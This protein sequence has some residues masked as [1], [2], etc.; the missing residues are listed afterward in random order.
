MAE[1]SCL[2]Y[3]TTDHAASA[4]TA[5]HV[6]SLLANP[7]DKTAD[8]AGSANVSARENAF[9]GQGSFSFAQLENKVQ[10]TFDQVKNAGELLHLGHTSNL[11]NSG[12]KPETDDRTGCG[13]TAVEL[14]P[15]MPSGELQVKL[16]RQIQDGEHVAISQPI[17]YQF[18]PITPEQRQWKQDHPNG[19]EL[20]HIVH[21]QFRAK[22]DEVKDHKMTVQLMDSKP[23]YDQSMSERVDLGK[24][25]ADPDGY[26]TYD[27]Y[28]VV[29][30]SKAG[31]KLNLKFNF[32]SEQP[33]GKID[34]KDLSLQ[35]VTSAPGLNPADVAQAAS[36]G[37]GSVR[38]QNNVPFVFAA[39]GNQ[40]TVQ[41]VFLPDEIREK[42]QKAYPGQPDKQ[43]KMFEQ[44]QQEHALTPEQQKTYLQKMK[45]M[46]I[47]CIHIPIYWNQT[48]TQ[49]GKTDYAAVDHMIDLAKSYGMKVELDP[50][51][52]SYCYPGWADKGGQTPQGSGGAAA[53][54]NE[55]NEQQ[56]KSVTRQHI[57]DIIQHFG[58]RADFIVVNEMN[59]TDLATRKK[60]DANGHAQLEQ[61]HNGLTDWV[62]KEGPAAVIN[63]VDRWAREDLK[64]YGST[65]K[66]LENEYDVDQQTL[67]S[68]AV[69]SQD[70]NRPDALGIQMH[71]FNGNYPV[72]R[73]AKE[74][75]DRAQT[76]IPDYISEI[77][78]DTNPAGRIDQS[79][80]PPEV[81]LAVAKEDYYRK[82]HNLSPLTDA[83]KQAQEMQAEQLLV[84]Y[85]LA[86][87]S[88]TTVG[89]S[90]WDYT[91][92]N[93][94]NQNTGGVLDTNLDPKISYYALQN[95]IQ[96]NSHT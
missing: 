43:Q 68:D 10:G 32:G 7:S 93:A 27:F 91:D 8:S 38:R 84:M 46:G 12:F 65:A 30:D 19:P 77:T 67:S 1:K 22:S 96:E 37:S 24:G 14:T 2:N 57:D 6:D 26:T 75:H 20:G 85:K 42:A 28:G 55:F 73:I 17:D 70:A 35:E 23:P 48:E 4:I 63:Q 58:N 40:L 31:N 78:V 41:N 95:L 50:M 16:N 44:Y 80:L 82:L 83:Q 56:T 34:I 59:S 86:M 9:F 13:P 21:V 25:H 64:K 3:E 11:A 49:P 53:Q 81:S 66:L 18:N 54:S 33:A 87:H 89:V 45:E 94:W 62:S 51:V 39:D 15:N 72:L 79:T 76:G 5:D 71:Q 69:V 29:P 92:R 61:M 52:W 47:D 36:E 60:F 90:L 88:S 74:L